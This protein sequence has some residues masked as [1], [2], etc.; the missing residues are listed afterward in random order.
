MAETA[1]PFNESKKDKIKKTDK[2][3]L[4]FDTY[5]CFEIQNL[6]VVDWIYIL[7]LNRI[8]SYFRIT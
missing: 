3:I 4:N 6:N 5:F 2:N 8:I 7:F 1:K